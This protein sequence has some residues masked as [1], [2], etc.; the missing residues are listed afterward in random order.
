M[1]ETTPK[2]HTHTHKKDLTESTSVVP[3][4]YLLKVK[5]ELF[6]TLECQSKANYA[7]LDL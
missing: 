6:T 4:Q 2:Q 1:L 7:Y 3:A 5:L